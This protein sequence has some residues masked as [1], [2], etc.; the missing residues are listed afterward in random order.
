MC[1]QHIIIWVV[2][3]KLLVKTQYMLMVKFLRLQLSTH[4]KSTCKARASAFSGISY[5]VTW[6]RHL[7]AT[8]YHSASQSN[9]QEEG[10]KQHQNFQNEDLNLSLSAEKMIFYY[11]NHLYNSFWETQEFHKIAR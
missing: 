1:K 3:E 2:T 6:S 10:I 11:K 5:K 9:C 8:Q 7:Y 4:L